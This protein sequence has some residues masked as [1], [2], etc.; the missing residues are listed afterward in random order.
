MKTATMQKPSYDWIKSAEEVLDNDSTEKE[1]ASQA[2]SAVA[3]RAGKLLDK[4]HFLGFEMIYSNEEKNRLVGIFAFRVNKDLLYA[5][6][7]FL[8]GKIKGQE[9]LYRVGPQLFVPLTEGWVKE[10]TKKAEHKLGEGQDRSRLNRL[11]TG[12]DLAPLIIPGR[13]TKYAN[14]NFAFQ[15][16]NPDA[17]RQDMIDEIIAD[18]SS[19]DKYANY[20]PGNMIRKFIVEDGGRPAIGYIADI[21]KSS[22]VCA[23]MLMQCIDGNLDMIMPAD[24]PDPVVKSASA[25]IAELVIHVGGVKNAALKKDGI[26][27]MCKYG[28]AIE[29]NRDVK[30]LSTVY[31]P[32]GNWE[33][34]NSPGVYDLPVIGESGGE[35]VMVR[36]QELS[37][38]D[39][40]SSSPYPC[41]PGAT[42]SEDSMGILFLK[43]GNTFLA[44]A[45]Y[46]KRRSIMG[47]VTGQELSDVMEPKGKKS[48]KEGEA[49]LIFDKRTGMA[50]RRA[51]YFAEISSST[52][53]VKNAIIVPISQDGVQPWRGLSIMLNPDA[54]RTDWET[55]ILNED[56][57]FIKLDTEEETKR[58]NEPDVSN[59]CHTAGKVVT[60]PKMR[61]VD[62]PAIMPTSA[63]TA[64]LARGNFQSGYLAKREDDKFEIKFAHTDLLT[65][66]TVKSAAACLAHAYR[67]PGETVM[68][69][70]DGMLEKKR[71]DFVMEKSAYGVTTISSHPQFRT[72]YDATLGTE[73]EFPQS[74]RLDTITSQPP[75]RDIPLNEVW[76]PA[77]GRGGHTQGPRS[78]IAN[79]KNL[80]QETLMHASP[81]DIQRM[82]KQK[83]TPFAFEHGVLSSLVKTFD[84]AAMLDKYEP[85][86]EACL[87]R[88]GRTLF[89]F[90]WKPKD[91][92]KAFGVDDMA[93]KEQGLIS[94][95]K[96]LGDQILEMRQ[97][98][99][100]ETASSRNGSPALGK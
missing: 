85:A 41:P 4:D 82:Q 64:E 92:E 31:E 15:S 6:I 55:G 51:Y 78:E 63:L 38:S 21:I 68:E 29:D 27:A 13:G 52:G 32:A 42:Q 18:M 62:V 9:L 24:L 34:V 16:I 45:D 8:N 76:D 26:S 50:S 65:F 81:E 67:I 28:F 11:P 96:A 47:R 3:Q 49:Y 95:F 77:G 40:S 60:V 72:N 30:G 39:L 22:A 98:N 33:E 25:E 74:F 73:L 83:D 97:R 44:P 100:T 79:A 99:T 61:L 56:V 54:P 36:T 46:G 5:P 20:V 87:D 53:G 35:A 66:E 14:A 2:Y 94:C 71:V 89:L 70:V 48:P 19:M 59:L 58:D 12:T 17:A 88:L 84:A 23:E 69:L 37:G 80:D 57:L 86:F 43:P 91:M 1:F 90:Y 10:L 7:F 75:I 93:D